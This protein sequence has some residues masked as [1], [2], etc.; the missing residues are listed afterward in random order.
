MRN[1]KVYYQTE[2]KSGLLFTTVRAKNQ[3]EALSIA[4]KKTMINQKHLT[5]NIN[6]VSPLKTKKRNENTQR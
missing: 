4:S 2:L 3:V 5:C 1:Y 6:K